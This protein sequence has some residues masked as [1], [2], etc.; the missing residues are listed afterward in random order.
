M[1]KHQRLYDGIGKILLKDIEQKNWQVYLAAVANP[2]A[3][4][5]SFEDFVKKNTVSTK[6]QHMTKKEVK[7]QVDISTNILN[8]FTP[9]KVV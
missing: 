5:G 3:E 8:N 2:C 7:N 9:P 1:I 4:V 6:Q